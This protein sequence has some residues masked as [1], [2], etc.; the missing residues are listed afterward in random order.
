M[1]NIYLVG[2]MGT[3]KTAAGKILAHK[4]GKEFI[5]MDAVVEEREGKTIIDIFADE[6]EAYFRALE[7]ELLTELS[8]KSD[9][10]ISCG[11]G[12]ICNEDN[13]RMLKETGTVVN[14]AAAPRT[15]YERIKDATHR[16]LINVKDP[17]KRIEM[18]LDQRQPYYLQAHH[19]IDTNALS[20]RE[21]AERVAD[22]MNDAE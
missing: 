19:V 16:P 6:G 5:E 22:L 10:V 2:F 8:H 21:V 12:L 14:L 3:G 13:L 20:A 7:K 9:L 11:G 18:L 15:I 4:L 1:K 17:L